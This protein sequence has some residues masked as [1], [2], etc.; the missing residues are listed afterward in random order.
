MK[1]DFSNTHPN[2]FSY[3]TDVFSDSQWKKIDSIIKKITCQPILLEKITKGSGKL[4]KN[5][6]SLELHRFIARKSGISQITQS[7]Y[8][9]AILSLINDSSLIE[10]V[11]FFFYKEIEILR[12]QLNVMKAG[13]FISEHSDVESDNAY[14]CGI[15]I[16]TYSQYTGGDLTIYDTERNEYKIRQP[17]HS[18]LL[19]NSHCNHKVDSLTSGFRHTLCLFMG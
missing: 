17:N 2:N 6:F 3:I 11:N 15:L 18:I 1:M 5:E 16:R 8:L 19:M 14:L 10:K 7:P 9:Q 4:K 13:D 12:M